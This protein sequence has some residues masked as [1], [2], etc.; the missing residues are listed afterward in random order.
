MSE[1]GGV[2]GRVCPRCGG[3]MKIRTSTKIC[4]IVRARMECKVCQH[5]MAATI[6]PAKFL[7]CRDIHRRK[8]PPLVVDTQSLLF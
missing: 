4:S 2:T 3:W 8:Q 1:A 6:E 5:V 7:S